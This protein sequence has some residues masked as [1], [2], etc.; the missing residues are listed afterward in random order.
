MQTDLRSCRIPVTPAT[1]GKNDPR[2]RTALE[3]AVGEVVY[4]GSGKPLSSEEVRRLLPGID[5]YIAGLD[6][7]DAEA[8]AAADRLRVIAR[9]GVGIDKVDLEAAARKSIV[10]ANT[11]QAN[12]VSVAELAI[13]LMVSL[14]RSIPQN[15]AEVRSGAW[16]RT[17]GQTLQGKIVGLLGFGSIGQEVARKLRGWDCRVL[18]YDPVA[19]A[20][21]AK[22]LGVEPTGF[23]NV[24]ANADFLSLHVPVLPS[25]RGMVDAEFLARMRSGAFLINTARGELVDEA[26]LAAA[27]ESGHLRGAA[28]DALAQEPPSPD[29]PLRR[30]PQAII[31][32]H[33]GAHTDGAMD[34]MGWGALQDCLSV[35]RGEDPEHPVPPKPAPVFLEPTL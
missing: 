18:V 34:A 15:L 6:A 20:T 30:L 26:A 19:D 7:I 17:R 9:Y 16:P 10:V 29:N 24:V 21:V 11:P 14:A 4:N 1:F 3:T 12:S 32:P 22:E 2:L 25:T 35:L 8:L 31:T 28:L 23:D 33:C 13:G 5:G 27:L